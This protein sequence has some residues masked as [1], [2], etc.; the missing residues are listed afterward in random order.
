MGFP[1]LGKYHYNF[2]G[3]IAIIAIVVAFIAPIIISNVNS[4]IKATPSRKKAEHIVN[5]SLTQ[6]DKLQVM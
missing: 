2:I 3:L 6:M 4:L 1:T 5:F